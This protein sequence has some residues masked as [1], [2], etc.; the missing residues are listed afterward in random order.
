MFHANLSKYSLKKFLPE[1]FT[2]VFK[3]ETEDL[4][5]PTSVPRKAA[6]SIVIINCILM[7]PVQLDNAK[8]VHS[9]LPAKE[10]HQGLKMYLSQRSGV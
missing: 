10:K 6:S 8:N 4:C 5:F 1:V 3:L 7:L 2:E 9:M